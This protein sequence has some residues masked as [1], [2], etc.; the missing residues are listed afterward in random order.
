MVTIVRADASKHCDLTL[1][2]DPVEREITEPGLY[3]YSWPA[4]S[5][6]VQVQLVATRFNESA[7]SRRDGDHQR[8]DEPQTPRQHGRDLRSF[9]GASLE[10]YLMGHGPWGR[11]SDIGNRISEIGSEGCGK[12]MAR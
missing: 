9:D 1:D 12:E 10:K 8:D 6:T 11:K 4:L 2:E 7:R 3:D 5:R